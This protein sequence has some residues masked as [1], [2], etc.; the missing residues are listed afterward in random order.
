MAVSAAA[1]D[2]NEAARRAAGQRA[3][4][5][6]QSIAKTIEPYYGPGAK[7]DFFTL[8]A[9]HYN[10]VKAYLMATVSG[11]SSGQSAATDALTTNADEIATFLS[12]ANPHLPKD[13]VHELLLAHGGHHIQQIQQPKDRNYEAEGQTRETIKKQKS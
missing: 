4:A 8:L 6:A 11:D 10:A 13:G 12:N 7:E 1:I 5:N 9:G 2:K 3:V